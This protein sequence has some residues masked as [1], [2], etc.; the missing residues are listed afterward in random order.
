MKRYT[1]QIISIF[2][3]TLIFASQTFAGWQQ[4]KVATYTSDGDINGY[5]EFAVNQS[6]QQSFFTIFKRISGMR[7]YMT[8]FGVTYPEFK[9]YMKFGSSA[10]EIKNYP[11]DRDIGFIGGIDFSIFDKSTF[12]DIK[13]NV[14][15]HFGLQYG[16]QVEVAFNIIGGNPG[17]A[18]GPLPNVNIEVGNANIRSV[19]VTYPKPQ[20][21]VDATTT[22]IAAAVTGGKVSV[23][24]NGGISLY[25]F[26]GSLGGVIVNGG[27]VDSLT[28]PNGIG[29]ISASSRKV[30]IGKKKLARLGFGQGAKADPTLVGGTIGGTI[31]TKGRIDVIFAGN[32]LGA[33]L[34]NGF[35]EM[36]P[37]IAC[38]YD[39]FA[40]YSGR[41]IKK[42]IAKR[43][44]WGAT[45]AAG[46][47]AA[48]ASPDFLGG[49]G[50]V[51]VTKRPK[52][53]IN[54]YGGSALSNGCNFISYNR[55]K[56]CGSG[57]KEGTAFCATSYN[58]LPW[59]ALPLDENFVK[60]ASKQ[61]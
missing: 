51:L 12:V 31:T 15:D 21:S 40:S 41:N 8:F 55:F 58:V 42:I 13:M 36:K 44:A 19:R 59:A 54:Y 29:L 34:N 35:A 47:A 37:S 16:K 48:T 49:I 6:G 38:G 7:V 26:G 33:P 32:G 22:Q 25:K 56:L 45:V 18:V 60:K 46:S 27:V 11:N 57:V 2:V 14:S 28:A 52:G 39:G 3:I 5:A 30:G 24:C 53:A 4:E 9:Y 50:K 17:Q 43:G 61:P 20:I 10:M 23:A 1:L